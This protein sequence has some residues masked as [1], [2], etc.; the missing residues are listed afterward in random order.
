[1]SHFEFSGGVAA[2][3]GIWQHG[4]VAK[5]PRDPNKLAKLIVDVA[6][7]EI[8]PRLAEISAGALLVSDAIFA[9]MVV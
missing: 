5:R 7:G 6:T 8:Q 9:Q 3:H 1:M 4:V 2:N